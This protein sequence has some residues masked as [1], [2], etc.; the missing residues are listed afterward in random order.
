VVAFNAHT[1]AYLT[2]KEVRD[3]RPHLY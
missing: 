3:P 1:A 2:L